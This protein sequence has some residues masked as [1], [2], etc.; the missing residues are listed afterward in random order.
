MIS[1]LKEV[2]YLYKDREK[3]GWATWGKQENFH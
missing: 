1:D 2:L 3:A